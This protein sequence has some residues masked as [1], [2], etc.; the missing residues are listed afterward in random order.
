MTVISDII[1]DHAQISRK[2]TRLAW[3]VYENN[4]DESSIYIAGIGERGM[5]L[6]GRIAAELKHISDQ[7]IQTF[8]IVAD[9]QGNDEVFRSDFPAG[10]LKG[11]TVVLTDDVLNTGRTMMQAMMPLPVA[12][13]KKLQVL[14][15]AA[16]S[17]RL[18]PVRADYVG[19]RMATTLQEHL[20]FDNSL[21]HDLKLTLS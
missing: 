18:F 14:V 12:E 20:N 21:E 3:Q 8:Q 2:L 13:L 15:L 9:K 10:K 17:H 5:Y 7:D 6:A 11:S 4:M 1:L 19:I 16:R